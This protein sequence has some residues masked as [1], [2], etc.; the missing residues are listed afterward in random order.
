MLNWLALN[1]VPFTYVLI[2]ASV[3][4]L[5]AVRSR[6]VAP[7]VRAVLVNVLF[8]SVLMALLV[9]FWFNRAQLGN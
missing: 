2:G 4:G 3:V 1:L 7:E 8:F 6:P 5:F 9:P